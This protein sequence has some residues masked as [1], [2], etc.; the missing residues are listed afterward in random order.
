MMAPTLGVTLGD[1]GGIGP[2]IVLKAFSG[3]YCL[4]EARYVI[5]G[6]SFVLEREG[7]VL[8]IRLDL[9]PWDPET[10]AGTSGL[11]LREV[12]GPIERNLS[13]S[14]SAENGSA[15]FSFFEGAVKTAERSI[16]QGIV[17]APISKKSWQLAGLPWHG[18]TE[19]LADRY[20]KAVMTF[21]ADDLT[22]FLLSHHLP[23]KDAL[24]K[25]KKENLLRF[26]LDQH[27]LLEK[28]RPG[29]FEF[30]VAGL[31]PHAGEEGFL[32]DEEEKEISP[33]IREAE[34]AGVRISGPY[35]ADTIFFKVLGHP[36]R[37][38]VALYHD[39]GLIGFKLKAF[40]SGVNATLGMPFIRT[41]P[42]HGT[43][44]DIA[45]RGMADPK[46]MVQAIKLAHR[47][48][49]KYSEG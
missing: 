2:E 43:A 28:A 5:F 9:K 11:F 3:Q 41:S 10:R 18:H 14:P 42:D 19:Y 31:N 36:E 48:A 15:S 37:I 4:P 34:K 6:S 27:A 22:V 40:E 39:Q 26:F 29:G 1:P 44:F 12:A 16:L 24:R 7:E 20:P 25:V 32:G 30:V 23:L 13:R 47:F 45:G 46:S 33:A 49:A 35:P 38:V 8:G 17:T 21:W